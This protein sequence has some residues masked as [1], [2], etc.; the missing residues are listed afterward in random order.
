MASVTLVAFDGVTNGAWGASAVCLLFLYGDG[1]EEE[2]DVVTPWFKR[3]LWLL[4]RF[5]DIVAG[6][7]GGTVVLVC[8][9]L[10]GVPGLVVDWAGVMGG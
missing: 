5:A 2:P 3:V 10:L 9:L 7:V 1:G 8:E 6:F 4:W